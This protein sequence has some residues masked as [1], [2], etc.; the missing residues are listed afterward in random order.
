M[1]FAY[2]KLE[3]WNRSVDF[4]V[5]VIDTVENI[6]TDRKHYRLLEQIEAIMTNSW[7]ISNKVIR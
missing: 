2:E 4:A 5:A 6:S 3:V 1:K 7:T